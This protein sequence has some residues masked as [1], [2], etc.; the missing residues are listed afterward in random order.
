MNKEGQVSI[1][2]N[3][4]S[5]MFAIIFFIKM[6]AVAQRVEQRIVLESPRGQ[7]RHTSG[8]VSAEAYGSN[9]SF[10]NNPVN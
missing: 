5:S 1:T 4:L 8:Q 3:L 6:G 7:F 10:E 2:P 9:P